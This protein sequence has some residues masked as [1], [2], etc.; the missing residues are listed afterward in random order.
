MGIWQLITGATL[1]TILLPLFI[2]YSAEFVKAIGITNDT[3]I[4]YQYGGDNLSNTIETVITL[5]QHLVGISGAT[6]YNIIPN[7]SIVI[8]IMLIVMVIILFKV[9]GMISSGT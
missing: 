5:P 8:T 9:W 2:N 4:W 3:A 7:I 1:I 6:L